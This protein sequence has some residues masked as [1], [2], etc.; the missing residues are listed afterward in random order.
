MKTIP[1]TRGMY[2]LVDDSEYERV[3]A[4]KWYANVSR[5]TF[6][7]VRNEYRYEEGRKIGRTVYLHRFILGV[8]DPNIQVDHENHNGLDCQRSNVRACTNA[9]NCRNRIIDKREATSS[10]KGVCWNEECRKWKAAIKLHGK[11]LYLGL[12]ADE[13]DAARAYDRAAIEHFKEFA[14]LNFP[15]VLQGTETLK[16]QPMGDLHQQ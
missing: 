9:Q 10:Y 14:V 12:F 3:S 8:E 4:F 16:P 2:A 15:I 6:C 13:G 7:A 1:L 5:N 11:V